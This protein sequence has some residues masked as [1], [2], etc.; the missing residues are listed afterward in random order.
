LK[1]YHEVKSKI[2]STPVQL[3]QNVFLMNPNEQ[4]RNLKDMKKREEEFEQFE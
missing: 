3:T 2:S 1:K 4:Q